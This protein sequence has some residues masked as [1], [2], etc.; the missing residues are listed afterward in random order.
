M[1]YAYMKILWLA[2]DRSDRVADIFG[3]LQRCVADMV[4]VD[5]IYRHIEILPKAW[6]HTYTTGNRK[7]AKLVIPK[8]ANEYDFT[9]NGEIF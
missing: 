2:T 3:P 4:D 6:Q 5:F 1:G 8:K 9:G 7:P